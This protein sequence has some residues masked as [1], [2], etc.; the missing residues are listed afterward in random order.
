MHSRIESAIVSYAGQCV[1]LGQAVDKYLAVMDATL[2]LKLTVDKR[3]PEQLLKTWH[4]NDV[5]EFFEQWQA[6]PYGR[7]ADT[8]ILLQ[9]MEAYYECPLFDED[10]DT[11][12][13]WQDA[14]SFECIPLV[15]A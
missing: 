1:T 5:K 3:T 4:D 8:L 10:D 6:F 2:E 13:R 14:V 11:Y 15:E 12:V 7:D 9:D